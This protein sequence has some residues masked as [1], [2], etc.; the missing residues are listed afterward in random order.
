MKDDTEFEKFM[1]GD[2]PV[3]A[4]VER[5]IVSVVRRD[6][7]WFPAR[8]ALKVLG[9]HGLTTLALLMICPQLGVGPFAYEVVFLMH[10]MH[11]STLLCAMFC[12][13]LYLGVS[14]LVTSC[15]LRVGELR[16]LQQHALGVWGSVVLGSCVTLLLIGQSF[17]TLGYVHVVVWIVTALIAA[18]VGTLFIGRLRRI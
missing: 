12:G 4:H 5:S 11:F 17:E 15:V 13:A 14:A 16:Y 3:G 18:Y 8:V 7:R 6:L 10:L 9:A 1:A 2:A